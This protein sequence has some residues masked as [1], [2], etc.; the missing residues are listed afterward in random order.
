MVQIQ[1]L[2]LDTTVDL[3]RDVAEDVF[4]GEIDPL[5][6]ATCLA[7]P[8]TLMLVAVVGGRIVGQVAGYVHHHPDQASELYIDN[9]GVTPAMRR[10]GIARRLL[11]EV[12]AWAH[13]LGCQQAWVVTQTDNVA[14]RATYTSR[15]GLEEPVMMFSSA[16]K[17]AE[18]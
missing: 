8:G 15:G 16:F 5:R 14:A 13:E 17:Q 4:D 7:S 6:L 10:R 2:S 9:L 11:D 3:F 12:Q 1:R 18:D